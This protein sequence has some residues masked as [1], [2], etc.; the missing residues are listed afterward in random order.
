MSA[1]PSPFAEARACAARKLIH[2]HDLSA[3]VR[4]GEPT[5]ALPGTEEKVR[6]MQERAGRRQAV[7]HP[8]DLTMADCAALGLSCTTGANGSLVW[9]RPEV[10]GELARRE[11]IL[12]ALAAL[13]ERRRTGAGHNLAG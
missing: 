5:A 11:L 8:E 1:N 4:P 10:R 9:L 2:D 13:R 12:S 7:H 3:S 6:A